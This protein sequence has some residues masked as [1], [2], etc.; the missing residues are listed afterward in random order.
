ML[1]SMHARLHACL[2][3]CA[4]CRYIV[5]RQV[6]FNADLVVINQC[7]N[8]LIQRAKD[9]RQEEDFEALQN[10]DYANVGNG[11][12]GARVLI[13]REAY[14][15]GIGSVVGS[16]AQSRVL[17]LRV[18]VKGAGLP[19]VPGAPVLVWVSR[20]AGKGCWLSALAVAK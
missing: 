3:P 4:M 17:A 2:T 18:K 8:E 16:G 13:M 20:S 10:R 15:A 14:K 7:M 19:R 1:G 6:Q 12:L 9:T 5:P 11:C